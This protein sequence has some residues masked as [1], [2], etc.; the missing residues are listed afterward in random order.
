[1]TQ[2][3]Y[4]GPIPI[5]HYFYFLPYFITTTPQRR[6]SSLYFKAKLFE[7]SNKPLSSKGI[8]HTLPLQQ[9][10]KETIHIILSSQLTLT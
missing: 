3:P 4:K 1:M 2:L 5:I 8:P 10:L 9:S 6:E 7:L